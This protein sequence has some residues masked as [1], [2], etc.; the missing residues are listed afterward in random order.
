MTQTIL[1]FNTKK[2]QIFA[3]TQKLIMVKNYQF[4]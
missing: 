1:L 2:N 3:L 4:L